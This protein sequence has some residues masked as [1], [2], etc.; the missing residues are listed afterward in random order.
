VSENDTKS[1]WT[2]PDDAPELDDAWFERADLWEGNKLVRR[3]RPAGSGTKV[4]TTVR[5]D[6]DVIGAFRETGRGWQTRMNDALREWLQG[7]P[8]DRRS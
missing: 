8:A 2:D 4:S 6:A 1:S 5:F 7:K 3:G